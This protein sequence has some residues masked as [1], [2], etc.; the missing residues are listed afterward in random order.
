MASALFSHLFSNFQCILKDI[1][2]IKM[3]NFKRFHRQFSS[4]PVVRT[5]HFQ[6]RGP[7]FAPWLGN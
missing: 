6:C 1:P 7:G 2:S 5:L 3:V 4:G